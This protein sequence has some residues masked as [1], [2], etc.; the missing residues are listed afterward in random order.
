MPGLQQKTYEGFVPDA[1]EGSIPF[2]C[3]VA[4]IETSKVPGQN[5]ASFVQGAL[6]KL[7]PGAAPQWVDVQAASPEGKESKWQTMH[8]SLPQEEF[9]YREKGGK[10]S[11]RS[12]PCVLEAYIHEEAG[13]SVVIIVRAPS[14]IEQNV[15]NVGLAE[16]AKAA[17]GGVSVRPQ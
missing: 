2:Y 8:L 15:G 10:E 5:L 17:A 4:A 16:L 7:Q 3:H 6:G 9:Y 14:S 11:F 13:F 12:M 1:A